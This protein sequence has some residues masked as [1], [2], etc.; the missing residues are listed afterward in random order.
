MF[1]VN[2]SIQVKLN[3]ITLLFENVSVYKTETKNNHRI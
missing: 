3:V 2:N 1:Y